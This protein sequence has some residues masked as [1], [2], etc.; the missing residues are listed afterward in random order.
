MCSLSMYRIGDNGKLS[1]SWDTTLLVN[2]NV[3]PQ[4]RMNTKATPG[5]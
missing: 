1:S 5:Q 2:I 3:R 4:Y